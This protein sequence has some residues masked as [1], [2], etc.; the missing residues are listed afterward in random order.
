[1]QAGRAPCPTNTCCCLQRLPPVLMVIQTFRIWE[2]DISASDIFTS[3]RY[4]NQNALGYFLSWCNCHVSS[5]LQN[6][7]L[8]HLLRS[9][10]LGDLSDSDQFYSFNICWCLRNFIVKPFSSSFATLRYIYHIWMGDLIIS[11][12]CSAL[13]FHSHH[14]SLPE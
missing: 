8:L 12:L 14:P 10:V 11:T 3:L 5:G 6:I 13:L 1:M 9:W 4:S 2:S 7:P